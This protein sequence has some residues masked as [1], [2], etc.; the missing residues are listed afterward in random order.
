MIKTKD[1]GLIS[2]MW[3]NT[4]LVLFVS[5]FSVFSFSLTQGGGSSTATEYTVRV[6]K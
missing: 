4:C 1:E 6:P 3:V 5:S 2:V